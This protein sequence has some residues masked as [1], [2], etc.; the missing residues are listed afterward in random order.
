[1]FV[2]AAL[3]CTGIIW[4]FDYSN[5]SVEFD[6]GLFIY[7][8]DRIMTGQAQYTDDFDNMP[9]GIYY[10]NILAFKVF[11]N[12]ATSSHLM[13]VLFDIGIIVLLFFIGYTLHSRSAGLFS[14]AFYAACFVMIRWAPKGGTENPMTFFLLA[15]LLC[16]ILA[17]ERFKK[18]ATPLLFCSGLLIAAAF[19]IKQPAV[20]FVLTLA[21]HQGYIAYKEGTLTGTITKLVWVAMGFTF[22][23]A[24]VCGWLAS[25]GILA[26]AIQNA[27]LFP[28]SMQREYGMAF[29]ERWEEFLQGGLF[30]MPMI[31]ALGI[32]AG[33]QFLRRPDS[34]N[35]I[36]PAYLAPVILYLLWSGDFFQHYL[37]QLAPGLALGAGIL[38]GQTFLQQTGKLQRAAVIAAIV[39]FIFAN[40][41]R[42]N[43][44]YVNRTDQEARSK[45]FPTA[46][47][48]TE[49]DQ[50]LAYQKMVG[51]YLRLNLKEGQKLVTSTPT[52]AYL[53]GVPN[54]YTQYY[55][56]P[57]T[58]AA[59]DNFKGLD[60]ALHQARFFVTEGWRKQFIPH[61]LQREINETWRL[62]RWLG[63]D[64]I[65]DVEVWENPRFITS[66]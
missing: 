62:V 42:L 60:T 66:E 59:S 63:E 57:L 33:I 28:M 2:F 61:E 19:M 39:L 58:R 27:F 37:I 8:A 48:R 35:M 11:G 64:E 23:V 3:L 55:I 47:L 17:L 46:W 49:R 26:A 16:Y 13:T 36:V 53:A 31:I 40:L 5:R 18:S 22:F 15:A 12:H 30:L 45:T 20:F 14:A 7:S 44:A 1:M 52:Y 10:L 51:Q 65:M 9:P 54:S 6:Q 34:K 24:L 25:K 21:L 43:D 29:D 56:A 32:G 50:Q 4:R 41:T 38:I